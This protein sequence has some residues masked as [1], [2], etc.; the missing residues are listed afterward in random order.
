VLFALAAYW[1]SF[2]GSVKM[3][4]TMMM[5]MMMMMMMQNLPC[6][7]HIVTGQRLPLVCLLVSKSPCCDANMPGACI[8]VMAPA[9]PPAAGG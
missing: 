9:P 3:L 2:A 7:V 8:V 4:M 1:L 5:M 6:D